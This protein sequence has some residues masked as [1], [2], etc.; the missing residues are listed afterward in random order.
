MSRK[1]ATTRTVAIF[2]AVAVVMI[3]AAVGVG[4]L[5]VGGSP[6]RPAGGTGVAAP[7]GTDAAD[8]KQAGAGA[9]RPDLFP[10]STPVPHR[11]LRAAGTDKEKDKDTAGGSAGSR[12]GSGGASAQ[13]TSAENEVVRLANLE[14]AKRPC[15]ALRADSRLRTAARRHSADMEA[16]DYFSHT[17]PDGSTFVERARAA[18]YGSPGA[19]N[20]ARGQPT[21]AAVMRGWMVS[22]G[23]RANILNCSLTTIGTGVEFGAGGPWWTQ[24][25]G[26]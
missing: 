16:R 19:E 4:W 18:G 14:R 17:A 12:Q 8:G 3:A 6:A 24:V 2:A 7:A 10:F 25:F 21:A 15:P 11:A 9:D 1:S 26:R 23:H 5:V 22:P 13:V 20:I